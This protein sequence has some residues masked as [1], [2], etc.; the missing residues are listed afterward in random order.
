MP[1]GKYGDVPP[2]ATEDLSFAGM[3][4]GLGV[5]APDQH[6]AVMAAGHEA[7]GVAYRSK[8]GRWTGRRRRS[9][10]RRQVAGPVMPVCTGLTGRQRP[11]S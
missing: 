2:G 9:G 3:V 5:P 10:R 11:G 1:T 7:A 6:D 4:P 8:R